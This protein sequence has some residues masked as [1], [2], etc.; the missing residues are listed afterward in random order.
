MR[1]PDTVARPDFPQL[2]HLLRARVLAVGE[3]TTR[4]EPAR[5]RR[6]GQVRRPAGDRRQPALA[7]AGALDLRQ[8]AEERLRVRMLRAVEEIERR[9]L[10]DDLPRVH[11]DY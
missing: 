9:R 8:R 7:D 4:S 10:L 2:R 5:R 3:R 11:D 1:G 6:I